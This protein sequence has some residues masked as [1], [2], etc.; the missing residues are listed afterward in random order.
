MHHR[1]PA[2]VIDEVIADLEYLVEFFLDDIDD[3]AI[4]RDRI[5]PRA[6]K[7]IAALRASGTLLPRLRIVRSNHVADPRLPDGRSGNDLLSLSDVS[8]PDSAS[9]TPATPRNPRIV[10]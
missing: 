8:E 3:G 1:H 9:E 2:A 6:T 5:A 4:E 7:A 10:R